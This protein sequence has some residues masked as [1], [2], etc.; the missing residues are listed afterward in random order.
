MEK[1]TPQDRRGGKKPY[2]RDGQSGKSSSHGHKKEGSGNKD[3][4]RQDGRPRREDY[5]KREDNRQE[6]QS[7]NEGYKKRD[8][9]RYQDQTRR[10]D[11]RKRDDDR[12]EGQ[13]RKDGYRKFDR[14]RD[15]K[16]RSSDRY[17]SGDSRGSHD[18]G[19]SDHFRRKDET[20]SSRE[21]RPYKRE[22][23][24]KDSSGGQ[25]PFNRSYESRG[26][27]SYGDKGTYKPIWKKKGDKSHYGKS[28]HKP[29][30]KFGEDGT[31]RLNKY[32]ANS[33]VCSRREADLL[34]TAGVITV[35]GTV[36]T[37][38]GTKVKKE[39]VVIYDGQRLTAEG[40]VY[41]LLNKP[42]DFITTSDD[43]QGRKT[44]MDLIKGAGDARLFPVGRLDRNTTGLLLL[45]NDGEL[46]KKLT[47][48]KHG[49][50]KL[51]HAQLDKPLTRADM[52]KLAQG[53]E[54]DGE[55]II[56]DAIA[57]VGDGEDKTQVGIEIHSGQNRVVR[58]MFESL[59]YKVE[60]L[61]RVLFAGL[62]KRDLPRGHWRFLTEKEVGFLKML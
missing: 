34:I 60:K 16:P 41:V 56:P 8:S 52:A 24:Q 4:K 2:G 26:D 59:D 61:D 20:G 33:G 12:F 43:P 6:G 57:Y 45:T 38:L 21:S 15:E 37:T 14:P 10:D 18:K 11:F 35:N 49:V 13:S 30:V 47:H 62:S 22:G 39:D 31:I 36:V 17:G 50:K 58:R 32:I 55:K 19:G 25:K 29:D 48:P 46:T 1:R 40:K 53:M 7:R 5:K 23:F 54:L 44:V 27:R 3:D 42:K 28:T 9:N 51:Y